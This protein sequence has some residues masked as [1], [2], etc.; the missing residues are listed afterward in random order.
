MSDEFDARIAKAAKA[1]VV[2]RR[3]GA[4]TLDLQSKVYR[5]LAALVS[6][7]EHPGQPLADAAPSAEPRPRYYWEDRD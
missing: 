2:A 1:Y 7:A 6:H 5:E 3:G 4:K